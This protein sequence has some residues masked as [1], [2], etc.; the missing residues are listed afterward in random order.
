MITRPK[1]DEK[2]IPEFES[3]KFYG[4]NLLLRSYLALHP[5]QSKVSMPDEMS[6]LIEAVYDQ[7]FPLA[8]PN[9]E[10]AERLRQTFDMMEKKEDE[11]QA[12]AES[13]LVLA[14]DESRLLKQ[15]IRELEEDNPDLHK[16]FQARTRDIDLSLTLVC[17]QKVGE[18]V[19]VYS[20]DGQMET[21]DL[22]APVTFGLSQKIMQNALSLQHK[23]LIIKL[24]E[25]PIPASWRRDAGLRYCRFALF[26]I[27]NHVCDDVPGYTLHLTQAHG[28]E[29]TKKEAL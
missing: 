9:E 7:D 12:D 17:L 28:L 2:G 26:D 19:A 4:E 23:G 6:N 22:E 14:P 13:Y 25:Q 20:K 5:P 21:F 29:I 11:I 24:L 16:T 18:S 27:D 3:D 8:L 15:K 10:W 1:Q